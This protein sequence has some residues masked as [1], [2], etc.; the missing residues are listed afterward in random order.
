[1]F[2]SVHGK[3]IV[4]NGRHLKHSRAVTLIIVH[5]HLRPGGIRRVIELATPH[6]VRAFG[7]TIDRVVL[8]SGEAPDRHWSRLF[9]EAMS[10]QPVE[11]FIERAFGYFCE[12][13]R[14]A[15][16]VRRQIRRGLAQLLGDAASQGCL[17]WAHNLGLARNLLLAEELIHSCQERGL[18]LVAHHHDWWFDNRWQRW[19]EIRRAGYRSLN[20]TASVVFGSSEVRHVAVNHPEAALLQRHLGHR[21]IWLP[22]LAAPAPPPPPGRVREARR[23]LHARL[24]HDDAPVWLL[25]CRLLR[26][27]NVA[28]ALLLT[29][30][31]RP[32]AWLVTTGGVSSADEQAY[33]DHL[34][35]AAR[36]HHWRLRLGVLSGDE[37]RK[38]SVPELLAAGEAVLLTSIQ[39]GF[40]LPYLEAAAATRPLIARRLPNIEADLARFGFRFP[41]AYEEIVVAPDLF[42]W[43]AER[44][45][46][47]SLFNRWK[48]E[49]PRRCWPWVVP[50][51]MLAT[52]GP[53]QPTPFS[54]LTLSA[55]LEVLAQPV[56]RSWRCC[57]PLNPFLIE[58]R[59]RA[60]TGQL[61]VTPWPR[62]ADRWLSGEA[63]A[64]RFARAA[65]KVAGRLPRPQAAW[66]AQEDFIRWKL[67][68]RFLHPLLW[69]RSP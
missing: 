53:P 36:A 9:R 44:R 27:K 56:S 13:R 8:A 25:P 59:R 24:D 26:R 23:W 22:N 15:S 68:P 38:P 33:H 32:E 52:E 51:P 69:S 17:V 49:I 60:E 64:R 19:R 46:Q 1:V 21:A 58:W 55:Q 65:A 66:A 14:A 47:Q 29:R 39:E 45:R 54:R 3:F 43:S 28:E 20:E 5:Y 4:S 7:G 42:D 57:A 18:K 37:T 31:L 50:P 62:S 16:Q 2:S 30:W 35:A 61:A 12:Q 10:P 34:G 48:N 40:G 63:Y 11:F 6:L 67:S 41:Q